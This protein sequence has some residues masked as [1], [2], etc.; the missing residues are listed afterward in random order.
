MDHQ[1][2]LNKTAEEII[3][4]VD[5]VIFIEKIY[6]EITN[7]KRGFASPYLNFR[8]ALFHY[9]KMYEAD[10]DANDTLFIEQRAC[11][12][13]HLNRGIKD[14]A[15]D[16][17]TNFFIPCLHSMMGA[18]TPNDKHTI[19]RHIYHQ[20]KNLVVTIRL[21]G[22]ILQSYDDKEPPWLLQL[23]NICKDFVDYRDNDTYINRLYLNFFLNTSPAK[24]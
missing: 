5:S 17:C 1:E 4:N 13:E 3:A 18:C 22:Q 7:K 2:I 15:I 20:F 6:A 16:L 9:K 23:I 11:L 14:S 8:D 21:E 10:R 24:Q 19:L 12:N